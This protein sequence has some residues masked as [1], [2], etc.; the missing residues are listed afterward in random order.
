MPIPLRFH[1]AFVKNIAYYANSHGVDQ[2]RLCRLAGIPAQ[3]LSDP[4]AI[5]DAALMERVWRVAVEETGDAS[6]GLHLGEGTQPADIG[7]VGL[8]MMSCDTLHAALRKLI[9][10]WDLM[11]NATRIEL[12]ATG[13]V[14]TVELQ[15]VEAPRNFIRE[16]R[17]PV[18]S[19]FSACLSLLHVMAGKPIP[20]RDVAIDYA[21]PA[22][23][24]EH[25]RILGRKPRFEAGR[26]ALS[27]PEE[28]LRW[29]LRHANASLVQTLEEQMERA[30]RQNPVTL[31]DRVRLEV[32]RRLR[33]ELPELETIAA[34]L[35][36]SARALQRELQSEGTTFREVVDGLRKNLAAEYL[37]DGHHSITDISFLLGFSEPSVLHRYF[38]RWYGMTPAQFRTQRREGRPEGGSGQDPAGSTTPTR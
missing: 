27:F 26:N 4:D 2:E 23:P 22:D 1:V 3:L 17:H 20:L 12:T 16:N 13:G 14:A 9:R 18:E 5:I 37:A 10:Y 35:G 21:E 34:A 33:A 8:A 24:R 32:V 11:S 38:R 36:L 29:P 25:T 6:F 31:Q 28:V 15:V 7:I 19:S 30:L